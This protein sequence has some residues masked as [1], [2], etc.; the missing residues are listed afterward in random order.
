MAHTCHAINC[1]VRT[2][3]EMFMCLRHW[4]MLPKHMQRAIWSSYRQG[5]CDDWQ[6][7]K[8]YAE[9]AKACLR[10]VG[11]TEGLTVTGDEDEMKLYDWLAPTAEQETE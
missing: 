11:E 7:T 10:F 4:R 5:Q 3:P 6:I 8:L 9:R 2:K 1:N